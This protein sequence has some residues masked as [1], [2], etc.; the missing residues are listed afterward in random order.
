MLAH[1]ILNLLFWSKTHAVLRI[2]FNLKFTI[3]LSKLRDHFVHFR[4]SI[5]I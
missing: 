1:K 3:F 5:C 4:P 2:S